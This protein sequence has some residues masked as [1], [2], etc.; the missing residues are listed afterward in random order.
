M[1][2]IQQ[3]DLLKNL[4]DQQIAQ[5]LQRPSGGVPPYLVA[6]E[7]KRRSDLRQRA[8]AMN[9]G[10]PPDAT[11]Q[12]DLLR[13]TA[14]ISALAASPQGPAGTP[15]P[16]AA[17]SAAPQ[18]ASAGAPSL[19]A[20]GLGPQRQGIA[21]FARGGGVDTSAVDR[22]FMSR[23]LKDGPY[24][25][26]YAGEYLGAL[27]G[28]LAGNIARG[29]GAERFPSYTD[30]LNERVTEEAAPYGEEFRERAPTPEGYPPRHFPPGYVQP[31]D[32]DRQNV[33]VTQNMFDA[34]MARGAPAGYPAPP[35][36]GGMPSAPTMARID[37]ASVP[38]P[39]GYREVDSHKALYDK[40][41]ADARAETD[42]YSGADAKLAEREANLAEA[43]DRAPW[44]ALAEAGFTAAAGQSPYA[45]SNIADGG[46]AGLK[47]YTT[48]NNR[49]EAR[50]DALMDAN[51]ELAAKRQQLDAQRQST[52]AALAAGEIS[53]QQANN[54]LTSL[55]NRDALLEFN[56]K[57]SVVGTN[58]AA[59][60]TEYGNEV[61]QVVHADEILLKTMTLDQQ[62]R[63][64]SEA[65][66]MVRTLEW[67][68]GLPEGSAEER[69]Y[70]TWA[71][72]TIDGS[73][74]KN[75]LADA[76]KAW[77]KTYQ[78]YVSAYGKPETAEAW[79]DLREIFVSSPY[80]SLTDVFI[81]ETQSRLGQGA[82]GAPGGAIDG[83]RYVPK[84]S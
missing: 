4:S 12:E 80:A 77:D 23:F 79:Q 46:I 69:E 19:P 18:P 61:A 54:E 10:A 37:P 30:F 59:A 6:S 40:N 64:A 75:I 58:N 17:P 1:N 52:S 20:P 45:L 36:L 33:D 13:Q 49:N 51:T 38:T 16:M 50:G 7:A 11:V 72:S 57:A 32:F 67:V 21:Q 22:A 66:A 74:K 71:R 34:A 70:K 28:A 39:Q 29:P 41:L 81:L 43:E 31:P 60:Q 14:G 5:Q 55:E 73:A 83:N 76:S 62:E 27:T 15:G 47:S 24:K 42:P 3:Q 26:P 48:A 65:P 82:G 63:I 56:A 53:S 78:D 68:N 8:Q 84:G 35:Q 2:L 9:V 25:T 44:M